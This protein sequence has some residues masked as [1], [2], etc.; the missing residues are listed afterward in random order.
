MSVQAEVATGG[1]VITEPWQRDVIMGIVD[2]LARVK[3]WAD[4]RMKA[5]T[6]AGE[7][8]WL[9]PESRAGDPVVNPINGKPVE[10]PR[11]PECFE[12]M[13]ARSAGQVITKPIIAKC[14]PRKRPK[15]AVDCSVC[16]GSGW[17]P[18]AF[19]T[20]RKCRVCSGTG[21]VR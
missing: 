11:L 2:E 3:L 19:H 5:A 14:K 9:L 1:P 20:S 4:D 12:R 16:L 6:L 8:L 15:S 13:M 18:G 7:L 21:F 10:R 17:M